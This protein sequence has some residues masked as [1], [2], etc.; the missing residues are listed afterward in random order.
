MNKT[1]IINEETKE[2]RN[3]AVLSHIAYKGLLDLSYYKDLNTSAKE[4]YRDI[5][6]WAKAENDNGLK[7][8]IVVGILVVNRK[9]KACEVVKE[10]GLSKSRISKMVKVYNYLYENG[11]LETYTVNGGDISKLY[12]VASHS[13]KQ[14]YFYGKTPKQAF[15]LSRNKVESIIEQAKEEQRK[16]E[17]FIEVMIDE[18]LYRLPVSVLNRYKVKEEEE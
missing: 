2:M 15:N 9:I 7:I 17:T 14:G 1:I 12:L 13:D 3:N 8:L 4:C 6:V 16:E 10:T 18:V 11:L 5:K